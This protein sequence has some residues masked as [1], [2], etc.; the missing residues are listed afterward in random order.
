MRRIEIEQKSKQEVPPFLQ[1]FLWSVNIDDLDIDKDKI[2]IVNQIFAFGDMMALAWLFRT[3]PLRELKNVFLRH[4]MKIYR[5]AGF[6]FVKEVLL[7]IRKSFD[8]TK[9][10]ASRFGHFE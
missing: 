7:N 10:V 8:P 1:P 2:Y 9:Y 5:R 3:Y 6:Y 4:G